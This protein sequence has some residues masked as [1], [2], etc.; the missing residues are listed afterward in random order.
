MPL[1]PTAKAYASSGAGPCCGSGGKL[2]P[3][4][5]VKLPGAARRTV[6]HASYSGPDGA[7]REASQQRC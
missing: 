1:G 2:G 3:G 6:R 5:I 4:P 7:C